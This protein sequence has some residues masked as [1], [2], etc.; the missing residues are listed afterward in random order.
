[1]R[2]KINQVMDKDV[3][4]NKWIKAIILGDELPKENTVYELIEID[5]MTDQ[6]RKLFEPLVDL[7]FYSNCFHGEFK[8][9]LL[10]R[11]EIKRRLGKGV[12]K[13]EYSDKDHKVIKVSKKDFDKIPQYVIDDVTNG[14]V[15]RIT[16][17]SMIS[18]T[19]Y[20][21]KAMIKMV[22]SLIREMLINHVLESGQGK[23][24]NEILTEIDFQE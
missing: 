15:G 9:S 23:K 10:L 5:E 8:T 14:N 21:K 18:T 4:R 7:Y 19:T 24:F 2:I 16:V 13:Y 22:D 17:H 11:E 6:Q 3:S 20:G 12:A 1:M